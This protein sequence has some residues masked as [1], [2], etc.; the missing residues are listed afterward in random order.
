M[1]RTRYCQ[2]AMSCLC[3][4]TK[5][6]TSPRTAIP[7]PLKTLLRSFFSGGGMARDIILVMEQ[8]LTIVCKLK[9]MPEQV[10]QIEATL[11][12]FATACNYANSVVKSQTTSKT[13]IQN[14]VY[15]ELRSLFGLSAN[16]A[17]RLVLIV[18]LP[19]FKASQSRHLNQPVPTTTLESLPLEK[20]IVL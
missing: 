3:T 13:T 1:K 7:P 17:V 10:T 12:A 5:Y 11:Q 8:L 18:R 2:V 9:P 6:Q 16:L 4:R 14:L 19:N 15:Q 20:R